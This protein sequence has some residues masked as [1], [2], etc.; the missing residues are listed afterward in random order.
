MNNR[1]SCSA[2]SAVVSII[3]GSIWGNRGAAAML[4]T[5]VGRLREFLPQAL[6]NIFTPY[7]ERDRILVG[8]ER[9]HF[10]DGSS[11]ALVYYVLCALWHWMIS[12]MGIKVKLPR[13]LQV[14]AESDV[15]LEM[16][17]HV[18]R[19]TTD[20]LALQYYD[21]LAC[22]VAWHAISEDVSVNR[23]LS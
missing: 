23:T 19:W 6:F 17:D 9:L 18:F 1:Q 8:D 10:F 7:P 12:K 14:I 2:R 20:I 5:T 13:T 11:K 15:M 3:G 16:G 21:D 22:H 4:E